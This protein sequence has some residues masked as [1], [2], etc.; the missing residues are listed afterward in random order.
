MFQT[1][2]INGATYHSKIYEKLSYPLVV[3]VERNSVIE[4]MTFASSLSGGVNPIC[5]GLY[6]LLVEEFIKK[7]KIADFSYIL[8]AGKDTVCNFAGLRPYNVRFTGK[9]K[10]NVDLFPLCLDSKQ[11]EWAA[12]KAILCYSEFNVIYRD[13]YTRAKI[14][15]IQGGVVLDAKELMERIVLG[16]ENIEIAV[17]TTKR[18]DIDSLTSLVKGSNLKYLVYLFNDYWFIRN[19]VSDETIPLVELRHIMY[20]I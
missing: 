3:A 15:Y 8:V 17:I 11:P 5:H 18:P 9:G 16:G 19:V 12:K 20:Y 2:E 14:V 6:G 1:S 7:H 10:P 4:I 13:D